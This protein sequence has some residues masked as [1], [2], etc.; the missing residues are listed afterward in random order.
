M[1]HDACYGIL[2]QYKQKKIGNR[3]L[4][5]CLFH[6]NCKRYRIVPVLRYYR[7]RFYS[8][9]FVRHRVAYS[10]LLTYDNFCKPTPVKQVVVAAI[11]SLSNIFRA[12]TMYLCMNSVKFLLEAPDASI[13]WGRYYFVTTCRPIWGCFYCVG[14]SNTDITVYFFIAAQWWQQLKKFNNLHVENAGPHNVKQSYLRFKHKNVCGAIVSQPYNLSS[15]NR[16]S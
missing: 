5:Q 1:Q 15:S 14:A 9:P 16:S 3:R 10:V 2:R 8:V 6:G 12:W 13:L 7:G 4:F 11:V